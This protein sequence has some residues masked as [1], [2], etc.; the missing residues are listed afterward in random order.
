[1][2]NKKIFYA[3]IW[4]GV[5]LAL[6]KSMLDLNTV[7]P[8]LIDEMTHSKVIFGI[9]YSVMLGVPLIFNIV[10]SHY[11]KTFK[12]KKKVLLFGIYLRSFSFLGMALFTIFYAIDRPMLTTGSFFVWIF[13]FSISAGFAGISY[14]DIIAKT[15]KPI[16]RNK[17]YATKQFI[18]SIAALF[19]GFLIKK[20]FSMPSIVY[21]Y[22]YG[23]SLFIGAFGLFVASFGIITIKEPDSIIYAEKADKFID[24]I[25]TI[26]SII[27]K[28]A[29]F[30][31][32]II[33][34][35]LASFSIMILPFYIIFAKQ[36]FD[37]DQSYIGTFLIVQITGTVFSNIIWGI[38]ATKRNAKTV[39]KVCIAIGAFLPILAIVLSFTSVYIYSIIFVLLGFIISGRR[40]G[41]EPYLLDIAPDD[42]RTE[43][44]GIRGTMNLFVV[45]LPIV[46][47]LF[48]DVVGFYTTFTIVS[49]V[50]LIALF[51][52]KDSVVS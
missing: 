16:E 52:M 40:V 25:K 6:T 12:K 36:V 26:P 47:G 9:L 17:L 41:F 44:L 33:I 29:H 3:F 50:M 42:R 46:G 21:P 10:F 20:I 49:F 51:L 31:N 11:L 38:L 15:M 37:L 32:F 45:I 24:F 18:G 8:S 19:G 27:K 34:E 23:I 30:K 28:D 13:L 22:Q 5:F 35:N 48:I 2:S 7:F 43:Y 14:A 4:H 1:M 39:V